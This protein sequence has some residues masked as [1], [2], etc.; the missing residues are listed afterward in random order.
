MITNRCVCV[1]HTVFDVNPEKTNK[2]QTRT[3]VRKEC[4]ARDGPA[5]VEGARQP[6]FVSSSGTDGDAT[7]WDPSTPAAD[8]EAPVLPSDASSRCATAASHSPADAPDAPDPAADEREDTPRPS[9]ATCKELAHAK[10]KPRTIQHKSPQ[11]LELK[12]LTEWC[13]FFRARCTTFL[14]FHSL[15]LRVQLRRSLTG[16]RESSVDL[17]SRRSFSLFSYS[18]QAC[19]SEIFTSGI[20]GSSA[21]G[22]PLNRCRFLC[23]S[24]FRRSQTFSFFFLCFF[25]CFVFR[26]TSL[27]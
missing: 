24:F 23:F 5:P 10:K 16:S 21:G 20:T 19:V 7:D 3:F 17:H 22:G 6:I 12:S 14:N 4:G 26:S 1:F 27:F 15:S 8:P 9:A 25:F 2:K 18:S 13:F 11:H